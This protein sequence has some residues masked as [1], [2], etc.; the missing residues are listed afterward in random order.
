VRSL[1]PGLF[2]TIGKHKA[3]FQLLEAKMTVKRVDFGKRVLEL[4]L[5]LGLLMKD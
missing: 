4:P 1:R 3:G 2:E 5:L